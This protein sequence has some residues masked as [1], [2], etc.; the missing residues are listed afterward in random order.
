[1]KAKLFVI[2]LAALI[3]IGIAIVR[4]RIIKKPLPIQPGAFDQK[5]RGR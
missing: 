2:V 1:M 3:V 4:S 5:A